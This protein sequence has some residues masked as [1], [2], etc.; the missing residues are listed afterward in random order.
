[1][2]YGAPELGEHGQTEEDA[3]KFRK[4]GY[5]LLCGLLSVAACGDDQQR[6]A[7]ETGDIIRATSNG[8]RNEVVMIYGV[9]TNGG[10][11]FCTGS[12]YAPR[13]VVTAAHC[14]LPNLWQMFVYYGDNLEQ[15]LAEL[16]PDGFLGLNPPPIGAPSHWSKADSWQLHPSYDAN[17]NSADMAVVFMDRKPPFDPLPLYRNQVAANVQVT[18]SGWGSNSAPTPTT[19]AGFGVQRTGSTVTLGTPTEADYHPDDPNPGMLVPAVRQTVI[20]TSGVAPHSSACFGDSG[21]P[22]ILRQFGQD[23]IAG[24]GYFTGLSCEDYNL[25]VRINS[26]LPFL[27]LSYKRGGQDLLK[28]TFACVTPNPQG[29]LTAI[30]GYQ[31]DNG[32]G[33]TIPYGSKNASARDTSGLRPTRFDPGLHPYAFG[34]DFATGQTASWT[35]SPDNNPTVTVN[36]T[37]SSP[38]CTAAQAVESGCVLQCRAQLRSSCPRAEESDQCIEFCANIGHLVV[39]YLAFCDDDRVAWQNCVAATTPAAAN[40]TCTPTYPDILGKGPEAV[41]C[42]SQQAAYINCL[43]YGY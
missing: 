13:V 39:D 26:F 21:G 37:A 17:L 10:R 40:W 8:G 43:Y 41:A 2:R 35:L 7:T 11:S 19:G 36:A 27:D 32:V 9:L 38:R 5:V 18:I 6:I 34:V 33:I 14:F 15:D 29:S 24:V 20:K 42:A 22:I 4:T 16:T 23:Y 12:Y 31:N 3:M 30:F 25:F 1:M 28:P